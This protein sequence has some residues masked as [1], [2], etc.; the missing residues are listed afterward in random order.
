MKRFLL[1]ILTGILFTFLIFSGVALAASIPLVTPSNGAVTT[2][3]TPLFQWNYEGDLGENADY[4]TITIATSPDTIADGS[5]VP[6]NTIT[7]NL[8]EYPANTFQISEELKPGTYYWRI[9]ADDNTI[10]DATLSEIWSFTIKAKAK[11]PVKKPFKKIATDMAL[12]AHPSV[13]R[14]GQTTKL[15]LTLM[16]LS[17]GRKIKG[18][19]VRFQ[20]R[21]GNKWQSIK[22]VRTNKSGEASVVVRP[23]AGS[24]YRAYFAG[25]KRY[26]K[27]SAQIKFYK[28]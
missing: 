16:H 1:I 25:D 23:S 17:N 7:T 8:I 22:L 19:I 26:K 24:A 12:D 20:I 14:A 3:T 4:I 28:T 21:N 5:F 2:D 6:G 11:K 15:V 10:G 13:F 9:I 18:K 27:S